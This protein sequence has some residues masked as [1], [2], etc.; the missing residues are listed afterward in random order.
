MAACKT[1]REVLTE[2]R[3]TGNAVSM[4]GRMVGFEE[5]WAICGLPEIRTLEKRYGA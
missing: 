2:I 3:N 5:F 4:W 1:M